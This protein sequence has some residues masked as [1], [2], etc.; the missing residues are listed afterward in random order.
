M[1]EW[2]QKRFWKAAAAAE[3][4]GGWSVSLDGRA[5]KTPAKAPLVMPT[6]ALADAVAAEWDAQDEIIDPGSMPFTRSANSAIDKVVP[7]RSDVIAMLADYGD[8]DLLCYRAE[9]PAELVNRQ[10]E[11]WD[12]LLD[13]ARDTYGAPLIM[14]QG[15]MHVAQPPASLAALRAPLE[16]ANAFEIAALH[17]LIALSGSLVIGLKATVVGDPEPLWQASRVDEQFQIDQ[18]GDDE[19]AAVA[20]S[21]KQQSFA[22]AHRFY[23]LVQN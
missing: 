20:S 16:E 13:W 21:I 22:D 6:Q 9:A 17:D 23:H 2:K 11:A 8:S 14:A 7:Q 4:E 5:I 15:V 10:A 18:W 3:V 1:S 12:P 19:E